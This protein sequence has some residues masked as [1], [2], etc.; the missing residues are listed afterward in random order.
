MKSVKSVKERSGVNK[1]KEEQDTYTKIMA[2]LNP[3]LFSC[4][5]ARP[6]QRGPHLVLPPPG[7]MTLVFSEWGWRAPPTVG[8]SLHFP[9]F[10]HFTS[11]HSTSIHF[12]S[13]HTA[14]TALLLFI[15]CIAEKLVELTMLLSLCDWN[16][17]SNCQW[18]HWTMP[19]S[20][21]PAS[22][23]QSHN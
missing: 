12:T 8:R 5:R 11:L 9:T 10:V 21:K 14:V 20:K 6:P 18:R 23:I 4:S 3:M 19:M 17:F 22:E 1:W 2:Y 15:A 13:V 16:D 7:K